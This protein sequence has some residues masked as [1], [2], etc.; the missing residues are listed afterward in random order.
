[1]LK[2]KARRPNEINSDEAE[3]GKEFDTHIETGFQLA[4]LQGPLCAEPVEAMA[5]FVETVAIDKEGLEKEIGGLFNFDWV[6]RG[7]HSLDDIFHMMETAILHPVMELGRFL[8]HSM[9]PLF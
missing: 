6:W 5:Y 3:S 1:M 9:K 2:R 4:T 8:I 7:F